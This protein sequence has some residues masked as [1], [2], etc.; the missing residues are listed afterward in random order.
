MNKTFNK[1]KHHYNTF[2]YIKVKQNDSAFV[3]MSLPISFLKSKV[4]F[5]FRNPFVEGTPDFINAE[6]YIQKLETQYDLHYS[7]EAKGLQRRTDAKRIREISAYTREATGI[8]FPTPIILALNV[9]DTKTSKYEL[10]QNYFNKDF[11]EINYDDFTPLEFTIID[12]QHRLAGL[13]DSFNQTSVDLPIPVTLILG[14]SLSE[15]TEIFIQINGN[16]R[17]VDRSMIYDLY[18]NIERV[19]YENINKIVNVSKAL[20]ERSTS[21]FYEMI[22]RLGIGSGTISQAFLIDNIIETFK[23]MNLIDNSLQE[24]YSYL[25]VY[26]SIIKDVFSN[27][28]KNNGRNSSQIV[29][30]NGIGALFLT[31]SFL[32]KEIGSIL[33]NNNQK[34]YF[35]YISKR[36]EFN[37]DATNWNGTGYKMQKEISNAFIHFK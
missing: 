30:T 1:N 21:P 31:M 15:A 28:W 27:K 35:D 7:S 8:V 2:P 4:N 13:V 10:E 20:N 3:L 23:E 34:V 36:K 11:G 37:W 29:K 22:K 25:F 16:Q 12:G 6:K 14:A 9:F 33:E 26:F 5:H 19:E 18:G 17:K 32:Y 24:I